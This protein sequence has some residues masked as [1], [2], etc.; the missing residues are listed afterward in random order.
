[1]RVFFAI[2]PDDKSKAKLGALS[3]KMRQSAQAGNFTTA[4]NFHVTIVFIGDVSESTLERLKQVVDETKFIPFVI[5]TRHMGFFSHG[6]MKD[7]LVWHVDRSHELA[8]IY[9]QLFAW[10]TKMGFS[11][12]DREFRPHFTIARKAVFPEAFL[13]KHAS[14][15]APVMFMKCERISLMESLRVN[16]KLMYKELYGRTMETPPDRKLPE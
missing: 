3:R 11:L 16:G 7:I 12:E 10:L 1:M 4:E 14:L 5:R 2:L 8:S 6:G 13:E 15:D 9:D